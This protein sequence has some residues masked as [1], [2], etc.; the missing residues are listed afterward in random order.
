MGTE[1]VGVIVWVTVGVRDG[2]ASVAVACTVL[3]GAAT[4]GDDRGVSAGS[5]VSAAAV[6]TSDSGVGLLDGA[7]EARINPTTVNSKGADLFTLPSEVD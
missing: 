1:Y 7:H 4:V 2:V 3:L 6:I 5:T